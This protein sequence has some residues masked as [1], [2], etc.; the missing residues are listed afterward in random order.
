[1]N[2]L[3]VPSISNPEHSTQ[4]LKSVAPFSLGCAE[5][6]DVMDKE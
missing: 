2:E 3:I 6:D 5:D 4:K 1:V